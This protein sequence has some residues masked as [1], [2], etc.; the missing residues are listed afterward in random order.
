MLSNGHVASAGV[1]AAVSVSARARSL[2]RSRF[3]SKVIDGHTRTT[4]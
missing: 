3:R 4:N 2:H 1:S